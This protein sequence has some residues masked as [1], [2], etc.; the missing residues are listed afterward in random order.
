MKKKKTI[1]R[2]QG[3][4]TKYKPEYCQMLID[5]FTKREGEKLE[6]KHYDKNGK[7]RWSDWKILPPK[8]PSFV[9]FAMQIG[10]DDDTLERW[11]NPEKKAKYPGFCGAYA[12]A[13][14]I[15]KKILVENAL[16]GA[17]NP[18]FAIFLAKNITDMKDKQEMDHNPDGKPIQISVVSYE[19]P[20]NG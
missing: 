2:P 4:P 11:A 10:V 8:F 7:Y 12:R 5:F 9:G 17:Y 20:K 18:Q 15:Q 14:E 1:K 16:S 19:P 6:L 3:R 13:K